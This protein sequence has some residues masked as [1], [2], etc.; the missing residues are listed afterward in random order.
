MGN[1]NKKN[2]ATEVLRRLVSSLRGA[3]RKVN[4][5][6]PS[7]PIPIFTRVSIYSDIFMIYHLEIERE[8]PTSGKKRIEET[9]KEFSC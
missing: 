3:F 7:R 2:R 9:Q 4:L 8:E 6:F 1:K 5:L